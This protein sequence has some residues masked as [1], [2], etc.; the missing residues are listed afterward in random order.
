VFDLARSLHAVTDATAG[1][2]VSTLATLGLSA[3]AVAR[4]GTVPLISPRL[5]MRAPTAY[6][7]SDVVALDGEFQTVATFP[8]AMPAASQLARFR[9]FLPATWLTPAG[10]GSG[11]WR[12]VS[13]ERHGGKHHRACAI[14]LPGTGE[15]G[16][17]RRAHYVA[18]PLVKAHGV[19]ALVLE[20]PYYGSRMPAGQS[21][22]KLNAVMDLPLLGRATIEEARSLAQWLTS[23]AAGEAV[24]A[25]LSR[26]DAGA[27]LA[28]S[29]IMAGV[30]MGGLHSAMTASLLSGSHL[31]PLGVVSWLGPMSAAPVFT[32]G[33]LGRAVHW[34]TLHDSLPQLEPHVVAAEALYAAVPG[35]SHLG[36]VATH[37]HARDVVASL[38][39]MQDSPL[40]AVLASVGTE[41]APGA[42]SLW[43]QLQQAA[44]GVVKARQAEPQAAL[45]ALQRLQE[46]VVRHAHTL[47]AVVGD[48]MQ[49]TETV[50]Q[51]MTLLRDRAVPL[52][53]GRNTP[54]RPAT[55]GGLSPALPGGTLDDGDPT[56]L[57]RNLLRA[58]Q[59]GMA[60]ALTVTDLSLFLP[61]SSADAVRFV[62]A[63][64]D[65]Y[66]PDT[67]AT[68]AA[69]ERVAHEWRGCQVEEVTAGHVTGSVLF[70]RRYVQLIA[71]VRDKLAALRW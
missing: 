44:A 64:D 25:A 29:V 23:P 66:V 67:A 34:R 50:Q 46:E 47:G 15:H 18:I 4:M 12:A 32:L 69:W 19:A 11:E 36:S 68:D 1:G 42:A 55:D 21:G 3:G 39:D 35:H 6:Y 27:P 17:V 61:P 48:V 13:G 43:Q 65:C 63:R 30:S 22:S 54:I 9:L 58:A 49:R 71:D 51:L 60:R 5:T 40:R 10:C 8:D 56:V 28:H 2:D 20:G 38:S 45:H 33:E 14:V 16:Y 41:D 37:H 31:E 26:V 59:V 57:P 7:G 70:A 52:I 62:H 24:A 53:R